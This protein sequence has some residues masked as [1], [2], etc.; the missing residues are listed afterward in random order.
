MPAVALL[1]VCGAAG[2]QERGVVSGRQPRLLGLLPPPAPA[3]AAP[4][5]RGAVSS[6]QPRLLGLLPPPPP[7]AAPAP[8]APAFPM[9]AFDDASSGGPQAV[10]DYSSLRNDMAHYSRTLDTM[11]GLLLALFGLL[12]VPLLLPVL[13]KMAAP[14][15]LATIADALAEILSA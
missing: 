15:L 14:W 3:P 10:Y 2:Q 9:P 11:F 4:V 12:L 13:L 6:R 7:P 1:L 5:E 8:I